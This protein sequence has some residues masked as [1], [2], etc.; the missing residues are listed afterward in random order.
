MLRFPRDTNLLFCF[1]SPFSY[2]LPFS[3]LSCAYGGGSGP[4][5][6][7]WAGWK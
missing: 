3:Y 5:L 4:G 2:P 1:V 7:N 6:R